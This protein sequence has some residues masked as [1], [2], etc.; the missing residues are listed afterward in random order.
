VKVC[1]N[2]LQHEWARFWAFQLRVCDESGGAVLSTE[3]GK[4]QETRSDVG[5]VANLPVLRQVGNLPHGLRLLRQVGNLPHVAA[6]VLRL[7]LLYGADWR[8][9]RGTDGNS[10][11]DEKNL[12]ATFNAATGEHVAWK[13]PLPGRGPSSPIVVAGRVFVT[14]SSG[15]RQDRLHVLCFDAQSGKQLWQRQLWATGSTVNNPFGAVAA[16]TPSSDGKRV[17]ALFSSNDLACFDLDG[18]LQWL[19]GLGHEHPAARNDVGMASSPVVTGTTVVVQL[20]NQGDSFAAGIDAATG[21]TRWKIDRERGA[22]W[23]SPVLMRSKDGEKDRVLLHGRSKL[24]VHDPQSGKTVWEYA[25]ACSSISSSTTD[26]NCVYLPANGLHALTLDAAGGN[27]KRLWHDERLRSDN[28]SPVVHG[29]RVYVIKSP[30]ILVCA[31][32]ADGRMLW[33]LRLK[34]PFWATPVLAAGRLYCVNHDGLVQVVELGK[35]GKLVGSSQIDAA[36][37]ASPAMADGAIY[38]RSDAHLWKIVP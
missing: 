19:R 12:P 16:N 30:G 32:A 11:S 22:I 29:S 37:L 18:N 35:E 24:T 10:V 5:Q 36:I 23:S 20:E 13:A 9:F 6:A 28:C 7:G 38:F 4:P 3:Q 21:K 31:D 27:V 33:Q 8:Q 34:G 14:A 1:Q 17:F 2:D 15:V 26:G 25:A